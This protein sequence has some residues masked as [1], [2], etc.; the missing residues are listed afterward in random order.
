MNVCM[1]VCQCMNVRRTDCPGHRDRAA[2][3]IRPGSPEQRVD[4]PRRV[5]LV[6]HKRNVVLA[7]V[8]FVVVVSRGQLARLACGLTLRRWEWHQRPK[9]EVGGREGAEDGTAC[10]A[11]QASQHPGYDAIS[12][13]QTRSHTR[14]RCCYHPN[15]SYASAQY[16]AWHGLP[17][18]VSTYLSILPAMD[19]RFVHEYS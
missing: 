17:W 12:M 2:P 6:G 7:A 15:A 9:G 5:A 4:N 8:E 18:Y 19:V 11:A 3:R 10:S 14:A 1:T 16:M 13:S